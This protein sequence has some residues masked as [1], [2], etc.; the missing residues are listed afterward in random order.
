MK[1]ADRTV[2]GQ[3]LNMVKAEA[4]IEYCNTFEAKQDRQDQAS[5]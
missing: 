3:G 2:Q 1:R 5:V 4:K